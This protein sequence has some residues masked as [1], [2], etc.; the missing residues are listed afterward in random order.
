MGCYRAKLYSVPSPEY[1]DLVEHSIAFILQKTAVLWSDTEAGVVA[2]HLHPSHCHQPFSL[3]SSFFL[4]LD[5]CAVTVERENKCTYSSHEM[6]NW[7]LCTSLKLLATERLS[8][9]RM[10]KYMWSYCCL[11]LCKPSHVTE[12][13]FLWLFYYSVVRDIQNNFHF[14]SILKNC[15]FNLMY[16]LFFSLQSAE[17]LY[18]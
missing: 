13:P 6:Q 10:P 12:L 11:L 14:I 16:S 1:F 4:N 9:R 7:L 2:C 5:F 8:Q 3:L 18:F 15:P 17:H